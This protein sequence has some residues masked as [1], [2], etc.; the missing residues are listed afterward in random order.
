MRDLPRVLVVALALDVLGLFERSIRALLEQTQ[1]LEVFADLAA[2]EV[3]VAHREALLAFVD[4]GLFLRV[5][6]PQGLDLPFGR[7]SPALLG[8]ASRR[9]PLALRA[10]VVLG[11]VVFLFVVVVVLAGLG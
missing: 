5:L 9:T 4:L 7:A 6:I 11:F 10:G 1:L 3:L 2:P 8:R